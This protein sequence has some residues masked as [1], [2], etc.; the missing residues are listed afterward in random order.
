MLK[1]EQIIKQI[2]V[3]ENRRE[4]LPIL[5]SVLLMPCIWNIVSRSAR[6]HFLHNPEPFLAR[7]ERKHPLRFHSIPGR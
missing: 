5:V 7:G 3:S 4:E 1:A 6:T 2:K